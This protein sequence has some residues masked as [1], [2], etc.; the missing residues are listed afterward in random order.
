MASKFSARVQWMASKITSAFAVDEESVEKVLVDNRKRID[1]FLLDHSTPPKLFFFFQP[2]QFQKPELFISSIGDG[3]KLNCKCIYFLRNCTGKQVVKDNVASDNTVV[4][5]ELNPKILESFEETLSTIF[6]PLLKS[7]STWGL[8]KSE[9]DKTSF[10]S[11]VDKFQKTLKSKISN[12]RGDVELKLPE[13][14]FD[15]IEQKPAAY[16]KAAKDSATLK[17]FTA[18]IES[19]IKV[20][21]DYMD[22]DASNI[23]IS[24]KEHIGPEKEIEYWSRRMLTLI[25]I[26][27]QLKT[28]QSRVVTGVMKAR[29]LRSDDAAVSKDNDGVSEQESVKL[30]IERWREVDLAITDHLNEAKDNVRFLENLRR[31][32]EPLYVDSPHQICETM[33]SVMNSMK[34][35]HTLSRHYGT[36]VRMT[37][38]FVRI[39]NQ[40]I[41]RCKEVIYNA[42]P[43]PP[44]VH[45]WVQDPGQVIE[46]MQA[47]ITLCEEYQRHYRDTKH[48][49][50][51][52]P[53]GKQFDFDESLIFG[54]YTRFRRRLEKLIDMFGSIQ[55]FKALQAK[56]IDG[57]E[58]LIASFDQLVTEFKNKNHDLLDCDNSGFERDFVEFTMHNSGL[59]NA[60]QDFVERSVTQMSS[61]DKQLD[62]MQ[63]FKEILTRDALQDDLDHKF[64]MIFKL[65]G[66]DLNNIYN[67]Y[68]KGKDNP[69]IPRNMTRC[70][71]NIHWSRQLLRRIT[72]PMTKFRD[73]PK[74]FQNKESKTKKVVSKYNRVARTLIEFETLWFQA[75]QHS[76]DEAKRGLR[77]KLLVADPNNGGKLHVNFDP[78]VLQLMRE[79]KHLQL[80][81]FQ[82]PSSAKIILLLEDKLKGHYNSLTFALEKYH[83][84]LDTVSS[85]ALSLLR[86]HIAD[87]EAVLAPALN[88]MSWTSMNIDQFI[89]D[90][91]KTLNKF[92]FL[93][94]QI[95]DIVENRIETNLHFVNSLMLVNLSDKAQQLQTFREEQKLHIQRCTAALLGKNREIESAVD[96]MINVIESYPLTTPGIAKTEAVDINF[97]KL[98]YC[99]R[100]F[101]SLLNATKFSLVALKKRVKAEESDSPLFEVNI[102]LQVPNVAITPSLADVQEVV[103]AVARDILQSTKELLDWGID[104]TARPSSQK[105]FFEKIA[106][107]KNLAIVLLLLNGAVEEAKLKAETS[108]AEFKKFYWLW[109]ED[110]E[111]SYTEF[112]KTK[113]PILEDFI[114]ELHR[115]VDV[116]SEVAAFGPALSAGCF[117]LLTST[118]KSQLNSETERWKH[119]YSQRLHQEAKRDMENIIDTMADMKTSLDRELK[120]I[121]ALKFVMDAQT[122]IR[123]TQTWI[124][125]KFTSIIERYNTLEKYLPFG[126]M[127][128]DE[129]DAKS[130]L[131]TQWTAILAQADTVMVEVNKVQAPFKTDLMMKVSDFKTAVAEFK[132]DYDANGPMVKGTTPQEAMTRLAKYKREFETLIRKYELYNGGEKLFGLPEMH[133]DSL[134]VTKKELRLLDQLYS[135]YQGVITTVEEYKGIP[136]TDVVENIEDM[137]ATIEEFAGKCKKLPK[138]LRDWDAYLELSKTIED[139]IAVL[140]LL[141]EMSKPAM[142]KRHWD[143]ISELTK[144]EFDFEKF[145]ELKLKTVLE[146]NLLEFQEDIEEITDGAE[147]QLA[148]EKKIRDIEDIWVDRAFEFSQW[149]ERGEVILSGACVAE[150]IEALE[151]SQSS[152][153]QMLTQRHVTP[154]RDLATAWLK[155]LS[156]VNDILESWVKVQLLWMSLEAVFSGGD[157]ARQMPQDTRVFM[158]VDKEWCTRMMAKA[159]DVRNVVETCQNEYIKNMLPSMFADLEKC[160]KALDGY[161]EQKRSKFPRFYFV[162]N[163]ALLLILSQ[164]SDKEAVQD[165]FAKVFDAIDRVEF[166]GNNI[167]AMR[168]LESGYGGK[169]DSEDIPLTKHV[170]AKGNIE[171][172]LLLMC[173]EMGRTVKDIVRACAGEYESMGLGDFIKKYCGQACLLGIQ[174]MWTQDV[175]EGIQRMKFEKNSVVNAFKKQ[176]GILVMLS[177][178]TTKEIPTKMERT[179]IETLVT[180]QVHQKDVLEDIVKRVKEKKL[181]DH[182]DFEWQKQLRCYWV[183]E[184]DN[185]FVKVADVDF[186]YCGEYLGC[187]ERLCVTPLT[188]RCY[189]TLTQALGM[190]F[191]GA[192]AGPAG[193]GKT[194]TTKDLG[195]ALGKYV[196]VFNCSDQMHTADTAKIYKGLCMSGSWG[197]FDEF[198]R[199]DLEV[200]SVVA[201]QVQAVLACIRA[202]NKSFFFP[203]DEED[204]IMVDPRCGFFITMNPGYAGRQELPENL[205]A[206]FRG[207]TMMVPDREIIIKVKLASV[208]FNDFAPL[209]KKF[210]VLYSLCEEQLSKQRHYDF[211]LRN[212]LSV[213]RTAGVNLRTELN[214]SAGADRSDLE[215][216]VMMRT[217]RDMNL[218]KLVADDC[219]LFISLLHDLFP[220]Q[221]DPEKFRYDAEEAAMDAVIKE[222]KLI[223]HDSWVTKIVQLYETSLVRHGLMMCGPAGGGKTQATE[224]LIDAL[225]QVHGK[226]QIV[227]MNPKAIKATEMFGQNDL[228]SGEWTHGIFSSIW[229]KYNDLKKPYTYIIC[230]GPVDAIWIENLNTVLDDNKLLT[231]ANGDRIPMTANVRILFEIEDLRNAS[232]ATVSRAGIVFVS[233]TDL[234]YEPIVEAWMLS[235]REEEQVLLREFWERYMVTGNAYDW[236]GRNVLQVMTTSLAHMTHSF[237]AVLTG[238]LKPAVDSQI[239]HPAD[240]LEKLWIYGLAWT[241]GSMCEAEARAQVNE[242]VLGLAPKE[243]HP[244]FQEGDTLFEW[245][246]DEETNDWERWAAPEWEYPDHFN[247]ANTLIPTIDSV[248]AEYLIELVLARLNYPVLVVGSSGTAKTSL[249]LQYCDSFDPAKMLLKKVNFSSATSAGMFQ[250]SI[251]AD[252][253]KRQGKTYAPPGGRWST[254]FLDDVSMPEVNNWG[255]QPTLEIVRQLVEEGGIYFLEKDKRGERMIIENVR[256]VAAMSHP[257]GGRN[258]IPARLKRHFFIF[259]L[260]P[261]SK[262]S[263]D[264]IYGSMLK[265]RLEETPCEDL[266]EALTSSTIELWSKCK[267]RM[268][269]T[270]SKFHYIFNMRD[271]SRVFQGILHSPAETVSVGD[272]LVELW[273]HECERVMCDKLVNEKDKNWFLNESKKTLNAFFPEET[274]ARL[275]ENKDPVYFVDFLRDD[276]IDEETD[277]VIEAAP[278]VYEPVRDLTWFKARV[279]NC[280][281]EYNQQGGGVQKMNLVLFTDALQYMLRISRVTGMPRGN[282]LL[283]GV[284]GSGR[285]SLTRL[286]AYIGGQTAFQ[287]QL[288]R[289]YKVS[290]FLEDI[291]KLYVLVGKEG[292]KCTWIF[293]DFE[294][295]NEDFLE[296]INAILSTGE[297]AGLFTKDERDMMV[298]EL[299][300]PAK[301]EDPN[302]EDTPANLYKY[303]VERIRSHLHI[304]LC[305]SP[306]NEKF[307]E[308][309]RKFPGLISCCTINWFLRWPEEALVAVS[310]KFI[311]QDEQFKMD[312]TDAVR[313]KTIQ[314]IANVHDLVTTACEDY[315]QQ[316]RRAVFVTPKSYLSFISAYKETYNAKVADIALQQS[317]VERGLS[318]LKDAEVDVEEMKSVLEVQNIELAEAEKNANAMLVKLEVGAKE[319]GEKKAAADVIEAKCTE[320][321]NI[322]AEETRLANIELEAAMPFVRA[323]SAAAEKVTKP[324]IGII[325][326]LPKPPDLIKRIMDCVL[327]LNLGKL[328]KVSVTEIKVGKEFRPFVMDSYDTFAKKFMGGNTF[329]ADLL[330]FANT[331]KDKINDETMELLDP[332]LDCED[333]NPDSAKRVSGAAEGLC[334]WVRAMH[335]YHTASL[336]VQPKLE[337]LKI[338]EGLFQVAQNKLN[339]AKASSAAAQAEVDELQRQFQETM[340]EKSRLEAKAKET[341]DKMVAAN[342]LIGSLGGEKVRWS[343]DA[344]SF[345]EGKKRLVGD[346]ALA[347]AFVSYLGP[348]NNAFRKE[349][350]QNRF[351]KDCMDKH[352]P[353]SKNMD[354]TKFL[355]DDATIAEWN[356]QT[357]PKDDLSIQNGILVTSASRFPLLIDPQGQA[358]QWLNKREAANFPAFGTTSLT[359]K[360]LRDQLEFCMEEGKP[361]LCEGVVKEVDPMFDPVLL[362]NVVK[363]GRSLFIMLGDKAVTFDPGFRLYLICKLGNPTFSPE[364]SAKTTIIDFSVTQKGLEDQLLSRVIQF[365]QKSL[366]DQRQQLVEEVNMNTISLQ[367]LDKELLQRLSASQGNLLDDV[368]LIKVLAD[369]KTKAQDVKE[370]IEA[371]IA[372]EQVINKK[373]EQ[374]RPVATRGSVVYFV[375]VACSA[376]NVMYQTSLAQF[377][378]Y[379]DTSMVEAEKANLVT[380]R[381]EILMEHLTFAVYI[382]ID[383]GLFEKDKLIFK[384]MFTTKIQVV[385]TDNL[386]D[387]M[388]NLLL[389]G[390]ASMIADQQPRKPFDWL[391]Q[392]V[393]MNI[394]CLAQTLDF[395]GDLKN[396]VEQ[397]EADWREWYEHETPEDEPIPKIEE[398]LENHPSGIFFRLLLLRC[399]RQDRFRLGAIHYLSNTMG[400]QYTDPV[401]ARMEDVWDVSEPFNPVI[402]MLTPGADPTTQLEE[403]AKKKGVLIHAV[404]MGEGQ[405]PF[406]KKAVDL[407]MEEGGWALLQNCHLG[408]GF[409]RTMDEELQKA[410]AEKEVHEAFRLW[411]TCEPHKDFPINLLQSSVKV[412]NEPPA[413]MKAGLFRSFTST[414]DAERLARVETKEWRDLVFGMCFLHS[415]VQERRKFGAIGWCIPYEY[416]TGDLEASLQFLEKHSFSATGLNWETVQYMVCEIQYGGRIT[417][418]FDRCLFNTFGETWLQAELLSE[419]FMFY[420][421][422]HFKYSVPQ[423]EPIEA[424]LQYITTFPSH[425]APEI[426]GLHQNADLTFGTAESIYILNTIN[427]TQPKQSNSKGG[428]KTREEIVFE[429]AD[430]LLALMPPGY[431]DETVREQCIKRT[432]S[433]NKYVLG[434]NFSDDVKVNG[435]SIPLNVFLYQEITRLNFAINN[436]RKTLT[437]LKQAINGEI[438][439]TPQLQAALNSIFD[440]KPPVHWY[441]DASGASIAWQLP[442]LA[443]WFGSLIDRETQLSSWLNTTRPTTYWLTGFFNPQGFLTAAR[444]EVTRRH[445]AERWA[446]DDVVLKC[447]V[448]EQIDPKRIKNPPEEGVLIHGLFLEGCSWERGTAKLKESAP[449]EL[450]TPLPVLKVTAVTSERSRKIYSAPGKYF[451]DCPCYAQPKR[452]D[453]NYIFVVKLE[454]DRPANHW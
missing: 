385:E 314:H 135:L 6:S 21:T 447:D 138:S 47:S 88:I 328:D 327:I 22:D 19:W 305:F 428:G 104:A 130:V 28:K 387:E 440:A 407:S 370:K 274:I 203:G 306:A 448:L 29:A 172:W 4:F 271:L 143:E 388:V 110:P 266:V 309:A 451:Y 304:V 34:M 383:R 30:M 108:L 119:Q 422:S 41:N 63:K 303:F 332:Y 412:T 16:A 358:L 120:D 79:A 308:R 378:S 70:A 272:T 94:Q 326:K 280:L 7:N 263:I 49:L 221:A 257:G 159:K 441:T 112:V 14:P 375:I 209:S 249:V 18:I 325:Q 182:Y 106:R 128:K 258:D 255:D 191:G 334:M 344:A 12:L 194:E 289:S 87:V 144:T 349:L 148:I 115:F 81:G 386:T 46:A 299:R 343:A 245:Y 218:S 175:Q 307:A 365:E 74:V 324:D 339:Q 42:P 171:E 357:L 131:K 142:R 101:S 251:E 234:G 267:N 125:Q 184:N 330:G 270:P 420:E 404:S 294:I 236:L 167:V 89:L 59:E 67:I 127:S 439:M 382:H 260:T 193:T 369:T 164:G 55:Q 114:Q 300:G 44:H 438:I 321:A 202:R 210:R 233:D 450:F 279:D 145:H 368:A 69:P 426:F 416:N 179:K 319:A 163:P 177:E 201:Q 352:I 380:K 322:I 340:D 126:Q 133:Y 410:K 77:S 186:A 10:V 33:P 98:H 342:N 296:Y 421:S 228:I 225:T 399:F 241:L 204:K 250:T 400:K 418:D 38:L 285:Q 160:Q 137:N 65:Y 82:I 275:E 453:L 45:L 411:I 295:I 247:F 188:D 122:E 97:V 161:L 86:P 58:K 181:K 71:G 444:Q 91:N 397:N 8:I 354:V 282:A 39:T 93:N 139:F 445:K 355:V 100:T 376:I 284:G 367:A 254:V 51:L 446:L 390:G 434:P 37:N 176:T 168:S 2:R 415:T 341:K 85:V 24:V 317:N 134:V 113:K 174:F 219:G 371:S 363:K 27:E 35:I 76:T 288:T 240:L 437:N 95:T 17:H 433:E 238:L 394:C 75:W 154:F 78:G 379:F 362:K 243:L 391:T 84:N 73:N 356:S 337:Q 192:P 23:P 54:K 239:Q 68:E 150:T 360:K 129:M 345:A 36:D 9:K 323:A 252:I 153:I 213:L 230:D 237:F 359:N 52:M 124:E 217:L 302:F 226:H 276:V 278:K 246:V 425:D 413:G 348:F 215:E 220:N 222:R 140:P 158:K 381:V 151:E 1:S 373:R 199:I 435:L 165:C 190:S 417:D 197:C 366:E 103:N 26:T 11:Q 206:L 414:V 92:E 384:L 205:K 393:W 318:K 64:L 398:R 432:K 256:F 442:S 211:G 13:A 152:L 409:M 15:Q 293:T 60:I 72:S 3:D 227:K 180:I 281:N 316:F 424:Y 312:A 178:M 392:D 262:E 244:K 216:M 157:I 311:A 189:I 48:K 25:S 235:R 377:L 96:D 155:K 53:K 117:S 374:Y 283:V 242:F 146:A 449:K 123:H 231:L 56:R 313:E 320:T 248:R 396:T 109:L 80:M 173:K 436:V 454:S 170:V 273:R 351:Y 268:L 335:S 185:C 5:G 408:L 405:E 132:S 443:L 183:P 310:T 277:E 214:K 372:T 298:S 253:E 224:V 406:A 229:H 118:L 395:F 315:F 198:N 136:W 333:F 166:Q 269:P 232:P 361:L 301:L 286:A 162:S 429:K 107:D 331:E 389:R 141:N 297:I 105:P 200:L 350:L 99:N 364:L 403:L 212:I 147:K 20:I 419:N 265:G 336:I 261:P 43:G 427:D 423:V 329:I 149:K 102:T 111:V 83:R 264:N 62:L 431:K 401:P 353:V 66:E 292:K 196:V 187:K 121:G 156:D 57:M 31:V 169:Q 338:K 402:L 32:I 90:L 452:T 207:V 61:I 50:S 195:R 290:D 208:G 223:P 346:C 347:C 116:E 40:L 259:N 287:I 291:R 430:E